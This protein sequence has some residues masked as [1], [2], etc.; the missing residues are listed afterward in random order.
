MFHI[1]YPLT[2]VHF[3][4]SILVFPFS[5]LYI[6]MDPYHNAFSMSFSVEHI[7][8]VRG[9]DD[10]I[11]CEFM[12]LYINWYLFLIHLNLFIQLIFTL[13]NLNAI[14]VMDSIPL[15]DKI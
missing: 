15:F 5:I 3:T 11:E 8:R 14:L 4:F 13:Q 9:S 2:I 7:S 1:V 12:V 10:P 6:T